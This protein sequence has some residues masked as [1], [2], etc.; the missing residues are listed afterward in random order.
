MYWT[1]LR[2]SDVIT[3]TNWFEKQQNF[4]LINIIKMKA[5]FKNLFFDKS[6]VKSAQAQHLG[7]NRLQNYLQ[8]GKISLQEYLYLSR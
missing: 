4:N 8:Q 1:P 3:I 2:P 7:K 6:I 5:F